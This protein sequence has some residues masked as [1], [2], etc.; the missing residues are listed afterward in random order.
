M[1]K[2][3][4]RLICEENVLLAEMN[5]EVESNPISDIEEEEFEFD[6]DPQEEDLDKKREEKKKNHTADVLNELIDEV[7]DGFPVLDTEFESMEK[8]SRRRRRQSSLSSC[9]S[10]VE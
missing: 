9:G 5:S 4:W 1:R 2:T 10:P 8:L 3:K 7:A 6:L